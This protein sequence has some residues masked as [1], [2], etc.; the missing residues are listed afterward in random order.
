MWSVHQN[1]CQE[2]S[3]LIVLIVLYALYRSGG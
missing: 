3:G 2:Y 1:K